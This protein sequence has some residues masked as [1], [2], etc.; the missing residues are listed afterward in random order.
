MSRYVALINWT[1]LGVK[2][3]K[4]TV[5]RTEDAR[6]TLEAAGAR[7]ESILWTQGRY[8]IVAMVEAPDDETMAMAMLRLA[9]GGSIRTET[10]RGFTVEE[11]SRI[12]AKLG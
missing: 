6:K 10:L 9:S 4:D 7:L 5:R 3:A 12:A 11:M 2:N 1:E 8:D